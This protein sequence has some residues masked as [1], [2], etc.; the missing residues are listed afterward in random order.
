MKKVSLKNGEFQTLDQELNGYYDQKGNKIEGLLS[1]E[2]SVKV[3][4]WASRVNSK[5]EEIKKAIDSSREDLIKKY[6][7]EKDGRIAV[8][9]TTMKGKQKVFTEEYIKFVNDYTSV[10]EMEEEIEIPELSIEDI[11]N[12]NTK[13]KLNIFFKLID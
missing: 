13:V 8:P 11:G 12:L 10:L 6:G 3:R 4:F 9:E 5:I 1:E 7:E 2:I